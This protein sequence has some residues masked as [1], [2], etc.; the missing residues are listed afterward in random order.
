MISADK[1]RAE[2]MHRYAL[3]LSFISKPLS[4]TL[5]LSITV[6]LWVILLFIEM[7]KP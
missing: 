3:V 7:L 2:N 6:Y 4:F 5:C 1:D